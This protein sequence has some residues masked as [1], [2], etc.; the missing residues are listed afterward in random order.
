MAQNYPQTPGLAIREYWGVDDMTIVCVV[1]P[2]FGDILNFNVGQGVDL[3][4]CTRDSL[5]DELCV[6]IRYPRLPLDMSHGVKRC[7]TWFTNL[8]NRTG[9]R[10][11]G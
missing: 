10:T 6:V 1:D 7:A 11:S 2:G 3:E 8:C 9:I 4:V 5:A